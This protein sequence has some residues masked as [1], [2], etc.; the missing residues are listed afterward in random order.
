[1]EIGRRIIQLREK[2]GL[3]T[4]RLAN[5]CGLSQSFLRSVE[6]NEKGISVENLQLICDA[7]GVSLKVFFDP[8]D[9]GDAGDDRIFRQIERLGPE[10]KRA[11]SDFLETML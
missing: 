9:Q 5:R 2:R 7:L 4:N 11:L 1:M 8:P 10:Q 6:L 3:S